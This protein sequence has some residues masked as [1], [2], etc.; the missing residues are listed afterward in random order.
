M[1]KLRHLIL[2]LTLTVFAAGALP[3]SAQS[4]SLVWERY[5]VTLDV[6]PDG[7]LRVTERQAISFTSGT[8]TFGFA[9]IPL[10][11]IERITDVQVSEPGGPVYQQ[12]DYSI[13]PYT[14]WTDQNGDELEIRWNFPPSTGT[15]TFDLSYTAEGAIRIHDSGDKLQWIA[16]DGERDFPIQAGSVTVNLPQGAQFQDIDSA[17]V[18]VDWEQG[19][20]ARSVR[21]VARDSM[22]P[23]DRIEIGVEFSHGVIPA[24]KPSW[25]AAAEREEFYDLNVR[26]LLNLGLG[27]LAVLL[28]IGLPVLVYVLWYSRGRDP[29]F[30]PVPD[31]LS[32][33]PSEQRPGILGSLID[34][35]ADMQD[36]VATIVDLARRGYLRIEE[37]EKSGLFGLGAGD[38]VFHRTDKDSSDLRSYE[39]RILRGIF[40]SSRERRELSDL[41]NK[42]YRHLDD[43][44]EELYKELVSEGYFKSRPDKT[45]G[46]WTGIGIAGLV[47]AGILGVVSLSLSQYAGAAIC[48]PFALGIGSIAVLVSAAHMPV[49]SRA[50]AEAA[51][52]W[53][54]FRDY[55]RQI[56]DMTDLSEAGELFEE[57]LPYAIA[58][59]MNNSWIN[60]FTRV[61]DAPAPGWYI[62]H[63]HRTGGAGRGRGL[64]KE[65]PP[66]SGGGLQDMSD[67]MAGG[68][69]SMSDGLT[70]MLNS[71]GRVLKSA[72]SSSGTSGGGGFSGGGFSSG[73]GGGGGARGFG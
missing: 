46:R 44:Q 24:E 5:D 28:G 72:P 70:R 53:E 19:A 27:F 71:T 64:A 41:R 56:E 12:T 3:A 1:R 43:I 54:A 57:Y 8:F 63:P 42:F 52:K 21:Y 69:Q 61:A 15:R 68:L 9:V 59:G 34:E 30:G 33:P 67:S 6:Q 25:Q 14:F 4:K 60:K 16:I 65:M 40:G 48:V 50:G 45:R 23:S 58:F 29:E 38:H 51:A 11:K 10:D 22:A 7:D 20:D 55:L 2:L 31:H 26:P 73:G 37:V 13:E 62:P 49:K 39:K 47:L 35:Q 36:V 17:G 18:V 32:E 66:D